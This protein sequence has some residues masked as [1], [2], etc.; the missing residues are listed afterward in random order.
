M[1]GLRC[2]QITSSA[3]FQ[4]YGFTLL[5]LL[6]LSFILPILLFIPLSILLF[7]CLKG[8]FQFI[9]V[10]LLD[11]RLKVDPVIPLLPQ[12]QLQIKTK[13]LYHSLLRKYPWWHCLFNPQFSQYFFKRLMLAKVINQFGEIDGCLSRRSLYAAH[14]YH[15]LDNSD[16]LLC[17]DSQRVL[18]QII[19]SATN[20]FAA[21]DLIFHQY[22]TASEI[23]VRTFLK[24]NADKSAEKLSI[25]YSKL[26][27]V[28]HKTNLLTETVIQ[29]LFDLELSLGC[30]EKIAATCSALSNLRLSRAM[31]ICFLNQVCQMVPHLN[32][33][34]I[35]RLDQYLKP[36]QRHG[37]LHAATFTLILQMAKNGCL[38]RRRIDEY[39]ATH[40]NNSALASV[41]IEL[42]QRRASDFQAVMKHLSRVGSDR[43]VVTIINFLSCNQL[44]DNEIMQRLSVQMPSFRSDP[45]AQFMN[46]LI[47]YSADQIPLKPERNYEV[48]YAA[49]KLGL[50]SK[51]RQRIYFGI[52]EIINRYQLPFK[53][54]INNSQSTHTASIHHTSS[55]SALRLHRRYAD[56]LQTVD[57]ESVVDVEI[58]N[59]LKAEN[60]KKF[61]VAMRAASNILNSPAD[62]I[63]PKSKITLS[64]LFRLTWLACNDEQLLACSVA[65]AKML[66]LEALYEI[67]MGANLPAEGDNAVARIERPICRSGCFNKF[68]EKCRSVH[69]DVE[70]NY[71]THQTA[72]LKFPCLVH[73]IALRYLKDNPSKQNQ[74]IIERSYAPIIME[75]KQTILDEFYE[76]FNCLYSS[77]Q[78]E[79]LAEMIDAAE[80]IQLSDKHCQNILASC[81]QLSQNGSWLGRAFNWHV[82]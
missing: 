80:Y 7:N 9:V 58:M 42:A 37:M 39:V 31:K 25:E 78:D 35:L 51:S 24:I 18:Q 11:R 28:L 19:P 81:Q 13:N 49:V 1:D 70:Q 23:I 72:A 82:V 55:N 63:D 10:D 54:D 36:L 2:R 8:V 40:D 77:K 48:F 27:H 74:V 16:E 29:A 38:T 73:S 33:H 43:H 45:L 22:P 59:F 61:S 62:F 46:R 75:L 50:E 60:S 67:Q 17:S 68:L 26:L 14:A 66:F 5:S 56:K 3:N 6:I 15:L 52:Y 69:P 12:Q 53:L 65:D 57:L 20:V 47:S 32:L 4:A 76:E 79:K 64:Y 44:L 41:L 30:V 21:A 71:V 34:D